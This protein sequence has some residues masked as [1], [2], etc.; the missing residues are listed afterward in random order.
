[1]EQT[2]LLADAQWARLISDTAEYFDEVT[3]SRGFTYYKQGR[4]GRLKIKEHRSIE[5]AVEGTESYHVSVFLQRFS[6]SVCSC[7]VDGFCKHIAAVLMAYAAQQGRSVHILVNARANKSM[8]SAGPPAAKQPPLAAAQVL[9]PSLQRQQLVQNAEHLGELDISQWYELFE[10]ST[11]GLKREIRNSAY[12]EQALELIFS[13]KPKLSP[14]LKQL[15]GLHA[16]LF[17]QKS[18]LL[19]GRSQNGQ[20]FSHMGYF[21]HVAVADLDRAILISLEEEPKFTEV[22]PDARHAA[23]PVE[24]SGMPELSAAVPQLGQT[25]ALLRAEMLA[26]PKELFY[27]TR[28]YRLFL[29][30]WMGKMPGINTTHLLES[31]LDAL[32]AGVAV[33]AEG[34]PKDLAPGTPGVPGIPAGS[35]DRYAYSRLI[36]K[37][38]LLIRLSRDGE[39]W[40]LVQEA[41]GRTGLRQEDL[42]GLLDLLKEMADEPRLTSWLM[43]LAPLFERSR[44]ALLEPYFQL[45]EAA[46]DQTPEAEAKMWDTLSDML[47]GAG[48]FYERK[49]FARGKWREW[50]DYQLSSGADPLDYK[51]KDLQLIEKEE[52]LLLLPFYHQGAERYVSHKNRDSYKKAVKLLKRLAKI[53]TR[54]KQEARWEQFF[55]GFSA[56]HSRLRALQEELRKGKLIP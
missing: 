55:E 21:T 10:R 12:A 46:A 14:L 51:A 36:A 1:M 56:R 54:T 16:H 2:D 3:L 38:R 9:P 40:E 32:E 5:A 22:A 43:R 50:I 39:A 45:W 24:G 4:V 26:E 30:D 48:R 6:D 27:F 23:A 18:L 15:F 47:P 44:T 19:A 53:Y 52:P 33:D 25:L 20:G 7:P 37:S 41:S 34:S 11:A 17:V 29:S 49:L 35:A 8:A 42:A 28:Y 31:E 13:L